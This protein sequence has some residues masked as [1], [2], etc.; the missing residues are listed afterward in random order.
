V[1]DYGITVRIGLDGT[2]QGSFVNV[3]YTRIPDV[4]VGEFSQE[5]LDPAIRS[6]L[7]DWRRLLEDGTERED[8]EA[9]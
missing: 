7:E 9:E 6:A 4:I 3:P 1:Q 5:E 2:P 8:P